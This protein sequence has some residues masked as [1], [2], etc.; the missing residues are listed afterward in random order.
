MGLGP[1]SYH[2]DLT[3]NTQ[4][5]SIASEIYITNDKPAFEKFK[6]EKAKFEPVFGPKIEWIEAKQDCRIVIRKDLNLKDQNKWSEAFTWF[7]DRAVEF[8]QLVNEI[9]K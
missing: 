6:A 3:I 4:K 9:D 5:R 1:H 2:I 8:K 7:L